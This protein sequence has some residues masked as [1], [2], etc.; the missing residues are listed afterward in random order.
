M[1]NNLLWSL[2]LVLFIAGIGSAQ[3]TLYFPQFVDGA[4]NPQGGVSWGTAI[5]ITNAAALGTPAA[6]GTITLTKDGGTPMNITLFDENNAPA[7]NTFQLAGGQTKFFVSPQLNGDNIQPFNS[8]F[9]TVTSN[10]PVTGGLIFF[11]GNSEGTFATAAVPASAALTRQATLVVVDHP[12]SVN[13]ANNTGVAVAN[14]GTSTANITFQLLDKSGNSIAPQVTRTVAANN[15]TAFFVT[16]LFP[17]APVPIFGT[18]RIISD[19]PIATTALFFEG[20]TFSTFPI[21]ALP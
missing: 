16:D 5:A 19:I 10:L 15:H 7:G 21:F 14:P 18:L 13:N 1:K 2:A 3:T 9:A 8:G 11:E 17:N 4:Q 12:N 20:H 6:S